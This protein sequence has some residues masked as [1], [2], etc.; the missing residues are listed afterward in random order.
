MDVTLSPLQMK[1]PERWRTSRD[2][3]CKV[4]SP[5]SPIAMMDRHTQTSGF[6]TSNGSAGR[7]LNYRQTDTHT[8]TRTHTHR[9]DSI[10][11]TASHYTLHVFTSRISS[12]GDR[13]GA[14]CMHICL[15]VCEHS[16]GWTVW[17]TTLFFVSQSI[18]T[19]HGD[20]NLSYGPFGQFL[21]VPF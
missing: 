6:Y 13:I 12:R 10:T 20:D 8:H 17:P 2:P 16:Q 1:T 7:P 15:C 21:L 19:K 4:P 3:C 18:I 11:S 9:T 14:A 5:Q